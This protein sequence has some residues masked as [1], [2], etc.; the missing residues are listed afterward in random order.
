MRLQGAISPMPIIF[1][2]SCSVKN[3]NT[4]ELSSEFPVSF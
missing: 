4:G 1:M 2:N 3:L